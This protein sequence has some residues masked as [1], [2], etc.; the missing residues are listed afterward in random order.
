[1][2]SAHE[3]AGSHEPTRLQS[4][5]AVL[6]FGGWVAGATA[7][8]SLLILLTPRVGILA[9]A[10]IELPVVSQ[11]LLDLGGA[12]RTALGGAI[13]VGTALFSM[14]PFLLFHGR[15]PKTA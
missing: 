11:W 5:L 8:A 7:F 12:M 9:G 2:A 10:E 14:T 15:G 6:A 3:H 4:A 13:A 1:M